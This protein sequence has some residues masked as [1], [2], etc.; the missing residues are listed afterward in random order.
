MKSF[1]LFL[2]RAVCSHKSMG[3]NSVRPAAKYEKLSVVFISCGMFAQK[4]GRNSVRPAALL[5]KLN[6]NK[7]SK[8]IITT[9][10]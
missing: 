7:A 2:F 1:R 5:F 8:Y 10:W 9:K 6:R 4:Y 3:R